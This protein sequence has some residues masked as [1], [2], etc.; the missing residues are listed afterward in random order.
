[1][2][3]RSEKSS[4]QR[5]HEEEALPKSVCNFPLTGRLGSGEILREKQQGSGR[6]STKLE[7]GSAQSGGIFHE[8]PP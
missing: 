4:A 8:A 5:E 2:N 3:K 1:M 7:G 6:D